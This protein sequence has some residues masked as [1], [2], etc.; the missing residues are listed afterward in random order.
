MRQ[1]DP[2]GIAHEHL[3]GP[4]QRGTSGK[5]IRTGN[6]RRPCRSDSFVS[7]APTVPPRHMTQLPVNGTAI[8][9]NCQNPQTRVV[10]RRMR[11]FANIVSPRHRNDGHLEKSDHGIAEVLPDLQPARVLPRQRI[12]SATRSCQSAFIRTAFHT[13]ASLTRMIRGGTQP[14]GW[15]F[16]RVGGQWPAPWASS[17]GS[18]A[19]SAHRCCGLLQGSHQCDRSHGGHH[20]TRG[21]LHVAWTDSDKSGCPRLRLS[22]GQQQPGTFSRSSDLMS[23]V[24]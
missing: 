7:N 10:C 11:L 9:G 4:E 14:H 24:R 16:V 18:C 19:H 17:A 21:P 23:L 15:I 8:A 3:I 13:D 12:C 5:L 20:E 22:Y 2:A 1:P 6:H